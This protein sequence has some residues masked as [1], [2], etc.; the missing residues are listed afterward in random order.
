M[1]SDEA[2]KSLSEHKDLFNKAHLKLFE[3]EG[4][5]NALKTISEQVA[6]PEETNKVEQNMNNLA[7]QLSWIKQTTDGRISLLDR[8]CKFL[9]LFHQLE[10]EMK[11]VE[12]QIKLSSLNN[13]HHYQFEESRLLIQQLYLQVGKTKNI[14]F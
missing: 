4:L 6:S 1:S 7:S 13:D 8:T 3:L 2:I 14:Y 10:S 5:R 12:E 9:K 11:I